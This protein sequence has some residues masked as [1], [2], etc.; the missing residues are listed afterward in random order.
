MTVGS[1]TARKREDVV[2]GSS[3]AG[4]IVGTFGGGA[5]AIL[6]VAVVALRK[7]FMRRIR[8]KKQ[9]RSLEVNMHLFSIKIF[10]LVSD[11]E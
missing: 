9:E 4:A 8:N 6:V 3:F 10:S 5:V 1:P 2:G 11:R 7:L